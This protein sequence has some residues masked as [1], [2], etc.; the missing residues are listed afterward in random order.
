MKD[1]PLKVEI[2]TG[3]IPVVIQ[4]VPKAKKLKS[5]LEL[6]DMSRDELFGYIDKLHMTLIYYQGVIEYSEDKSEKWKY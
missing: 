4:T 6:N 2:D 1:K 5:P 3:H